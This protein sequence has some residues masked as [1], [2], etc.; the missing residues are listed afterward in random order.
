MRVSR[1]QGCLYPSL[2]LIYTDYP[3]IFLRLVEKVMRQILWILGVSVLMLVLFACEGEEAGCPGDDNGQLRDATTDDADIGTTEGVSDLVT[4]ESPDVTPDETPEVTADATTDAIPDETSDLTPDETS[5][6]TPD[7]TTDAIPDETSDLTP[8][9]TSEAD[10]TSS[11]VC[12]EF[13]EA[14]RAMSTAGT[15][16]AS[17]NHY[18]VCGELSECG[19]CRD[20]TSLPDS[21]IEQTIGNPWGDPFCWWY[22]E[23]VCGPET[24]ISDRCCY[25]FVFEAIICA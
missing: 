8:D 3:D 16:D 11:P 14:T 2:L 23:A 7:A 1:G 19:S 4:D 18:L 22:A 13:V 24:T 9:E 21:Y 15:I 5:D 25:E 12:G 10:T 6:L 20:Y 17:G